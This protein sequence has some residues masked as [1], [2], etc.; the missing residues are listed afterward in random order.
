MSGKVSTIGKVTKGAL[1]AS[2][3]TVAAAI[4]APGAQAGSFTED[5]CKIIAGTGGRVMQAL[6]AETLS[7]EFRES[8]RLFLAPDG[9]TLTCTGPMDI[10]TPTGADIDAFNTIR[11]MLLSGGDWRI[12]LQEAG[13]RSVGP[14]AMLNVRP[15]TAPPTP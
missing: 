10:Y 9:R 14:E 15:M 2:A 5:Q 4:T 6:G 1:L 7:R 3:M 13:L 12:S 11:G 8:Y